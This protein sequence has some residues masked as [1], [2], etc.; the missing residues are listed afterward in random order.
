MNSI[1]IASNA[2]SSKAREAKNTPNIPAEFFSANL[3]AG[4]VRRPNIDAMPWGPAV[5]ALCTSGF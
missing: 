2:A 4:G 1:L 5:E 3:G